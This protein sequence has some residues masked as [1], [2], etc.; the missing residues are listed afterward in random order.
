MKKETDWYIG[1]IQDQTFMSFK[2]KKSA[3]RYVKSKKKGQP[4]HKA[5]IKK[6]VRVLKVI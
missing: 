5:K 4:Y 2:T 6:L 3:Q 1:N